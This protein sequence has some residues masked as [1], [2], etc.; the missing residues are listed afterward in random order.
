MPRTSR[1]PNILFIMDD[2]HRYD[3]T[4]AFRP[5]LI[6]TPNLDRLAARGMVFTHCCTTSPLCGPARISLATGMLPSTTGIL[7]NHDSFMPTG[8]HNHY[9]HFRDHGYRVEL[10]GRHDL[11]KPG[12]PGSIWGNRPL[13]FS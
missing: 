3:F 4:S 2:Q 11:S 10:V 6:S 5:G 1:Q 7:T 12:A 13:N 9:K 8:L